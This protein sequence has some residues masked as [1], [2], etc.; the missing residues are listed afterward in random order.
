MVGLAAV[1]GA[2]VRL[3]PLSMHHPLLDTSALQQALMRH[4]TR[5]LIN[6]MYKVVASVDI[7]GA[8]R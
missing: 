7:L 4:Y 5:A 8:A 3:A 2:R 1:E 6:E